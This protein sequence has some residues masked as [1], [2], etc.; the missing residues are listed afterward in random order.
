MLAGVTKLAIPLLLPVIHACMD[1]LLLRAAMQQARQ[2]QRNDDFDYGG[3]AEPE[4]G[5]AGLMHAVGLAGLGVGLSTY[6]NFTVS[7]TVGGFER[8]GWDC[9]GRS[10][11]WSSHCGVVWCVM[12]R[13]RA[14]ARTRPTCSEAKAAR[15]HQTCPPLACVMSLRLQ[16]LSQEILLC[17]PE[18]CR[19]S[20]LAAPA[21]LVFGAHSFAFGER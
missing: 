12:V 18:A 11:V 13:T 19:C 8:L 4:P 6:N 16:L 10:L 3:T 7:M 1:Q 17:W 9:A 21:P 20:F 14:R 2:A 15:Q 5:W